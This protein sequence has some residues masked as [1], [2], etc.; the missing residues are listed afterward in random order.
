MARNPS[1]YPTPAQLQILR[2]LWTHGPRTCREVHDI[3]GP[4]NGVGY[5]TILKLMQVMATKGF[6]VRDEN[7]RSHVYRA[8]LSEAKT[9]RAMVKDLIFE[10]DNRSVRLAPKRLDRKPIGECEVAK[11]P[12]TKCSA[13]SRV[14]PVS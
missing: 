4:R 6:V 1:S 10:S 2:I 7:Q 8:K 13:G 11:S 9:K 12:A 5:T 14:M 3:L